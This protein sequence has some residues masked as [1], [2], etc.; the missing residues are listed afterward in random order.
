MQRRFVLLL[1]VTTV[2]LASFPAVGSATF[3]PGPNGK[4][5]FTSGRPS[6]G[7][8]APNTNDPG[9]RIY[10]ADWPSGTPVQVTTKPARGDNSA[11]SA[12]LVA[13]PHA[14]RLRRRESGANYAIW[15]LDLRTGSQTEFVAA[16]AETDRPSWSPDGTEIAYGSMGDLWVKGV[17]PGSSPVQLTKT[18]G[19]PRNGRSGARTA[20]PSITT[21]AS[22]R[23]S[24]QQTG[25]LQ[26]EPGH[27]GRRRK[28]HPR[29]RG[30]RV[31]A[32]A[33]SRRQNA[34]LHAGPA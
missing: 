30:R 28:I 21:A 33:L 24:R 18:A 29:H 31:A 27:A 8:P 14:D 5:A 17:A 1:A 6:I 34:L 7:V 22:R 19:T 13:R 11:P 15:I 32:L 2:V 9:A 12:E 10:V 3:I 4:I 16:A 26:E 23:S 20:T 25:P